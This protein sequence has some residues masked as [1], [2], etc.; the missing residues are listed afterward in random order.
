MENSIYVG[1]SRQSALRREL[2][3]VAN[4]IANINTTS[5]KR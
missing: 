1:L 2:A 4:N 5:F 3:L